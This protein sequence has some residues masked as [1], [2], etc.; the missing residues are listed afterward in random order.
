M[1][2]N[3]LIY[4][5][6]SLIP[7]GKVLTYGQ[8][9]HFLEINSSRLIGQVIHQNPN[10]EII[11]CHR[12]VFGDGYLSKKYAFGGEEVQWKKLKKEGVIFLKTKKSLKVNLKTS[13]WL[14]TR[15]LKIYFFLLKKFGFP[16]PWPW[17]SKGKQATVEE[18]IISSILTQNTSWNNVEIALENLRTAKLN[19]LKKIYLY[20]QKNFYHFKKFIQPAGFYNQKSKYLFNTAK[21]F[22]EKYHN[23]KKFG[24]LSLI[25][26]RKELL[27]IKGVGEE[28]AD[29]ILL[30]AFNKPVFVIDNYTRRLV[31]TYQLV[32]N[33]TYSVLQQYFQNQLP[34]NVKLFQNYHALIVKWGKES[35]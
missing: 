13:T 25:D 29:T 27:M 23:L 20:A 6:V 31:K 15:P 8:I 11:P 1:K 22:V 2:K 26:A 32:N 24:N 5:L 7:E 30:Y 33:L 16:G 12:V 9:S 35:R 34:S 18:I 10:P 28:T 19:S 21:F 4:H 17:F 14:L 3:D